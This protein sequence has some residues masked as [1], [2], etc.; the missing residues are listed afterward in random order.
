MS[1]YKGQFSY[2]NIYYGLKSDNLKW[3]SSSFEQ[4]QVFPILVA[5]MIFSTGPWPRLQKGRKIPV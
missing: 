3:R 1:N 5:Q 4:I 2:S